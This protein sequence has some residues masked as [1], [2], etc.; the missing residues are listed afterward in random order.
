MK[1]HFFSAVWFCVVILIL[2]FGFSGC[3]GKDNLLS[4]VSGAWE[5]KNGGGPAE[6]VHINLTGENKTIVIGNQ[7]YPAEIETIYPDS[8]QVQLKVQN[9]NGETQ[10]WK[11]RQIWQDNGSDFNL[12]LDRAGK[13]ETLT[14]KS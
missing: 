9:G 3:A 14:P 12:A 6:E 2:G 5:K 8:F 4:D 10:T 13:K 11:I 1:N 7:S